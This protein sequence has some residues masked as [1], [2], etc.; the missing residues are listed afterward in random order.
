MSVFKFFLQRM[1]FMNFVQLSGS[2]QLCEL[3][4]PFQAVCQAVRVKW[5]ENKQTEFDKTFAS[6]PTIYVR[7]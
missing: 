2:L 4:S 3:K 5:P 6:A 7:V 1:P